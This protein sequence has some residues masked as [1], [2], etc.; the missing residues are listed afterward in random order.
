MVDTGP[1]ERIARI[2]QEGP[3]PEPGIIPI[4]GVPCCVTG[5]RADS[6]RGTLQGGE[7][8]LCG[9]RGR[10]DEPCIAVWLMDDTPGTFADYTAFVR[11]YRA[12]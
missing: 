5:C 11:A 8:M 9:G 4:P 3:L 2:L 12:Q 7:P 1:T 10:N 6:R